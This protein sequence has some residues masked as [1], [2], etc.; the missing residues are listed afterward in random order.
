MNIENLEID[1]LPVEK[2]THIYGAIDIS[3]EVQY[4]GETKRIST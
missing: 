3:K 1:Y 2:V 4:D